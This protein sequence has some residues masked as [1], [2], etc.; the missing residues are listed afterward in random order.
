M[1]KNSTDM[2]Q[3]F[4]EL[5]T[6]SNQT[7]AEAAASIW[8]E[9]FERSAWERL[10]DAPFSLGTAGVS[11]IGH[12]RAVLLHALAIADSLQTIH[13]LDVSVERDVLI[14]GCL[15][16]DVDK[17]LA[18]APDGK[19]GYA[20]TEIGRSFQHGFYSAYYA[21]KAGLPACIVTMIINH[22]AFSRM[23]PATLESTILYFADMA[24]AEVVKFTYGHPSSVLKAI[25]KLPVHQPEAKTIA[26]KQERRKPE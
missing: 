21:E 17:L 12:T 19:G 8:S 4:P 20:P 15:L 3:V 25:G 1:K 10:E 6:I 5:D 7:W 22:T 11:L 16:H 24:D 26:C 18:L 23:M 14:V 13:G 9:V 2:R